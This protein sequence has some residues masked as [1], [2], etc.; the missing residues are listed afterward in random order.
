MW[1]AMENKNI[2]LG[3][4][5]KEGW[6]WS[7]RLCPLCFQAAETVDHIFVHCRFTTHIWNLV[8]P[9]LKIIGSWASRTLRTSFECWISAVPASYKTLPCFVCWAIWNYRN[10][11]LFEGKTLDVH[12]Q[13]ITGA[14]GEWFQ[15]EG[16][17]KPRILRAQSF[18]RRSHSAFLTVLH[19]QDRKEG[20]LECFYKVKKL[21]MWMGARMINNN[22]NA[23]AFF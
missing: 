12:I 18:L 11:K 17:K 5:C 19:S 7:Q 6:I 2:K 1:L 20:E 15:V 3:Q 10:R 21:R 4:L 9:F 22:Q 16:S 14:I 8:R 13:S 23:I